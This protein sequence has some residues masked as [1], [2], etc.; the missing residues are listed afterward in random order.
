VVALHYSNF[1]SQ[2]IAGTWKVASTCKRFVP[3]PEFKQG[4]GPICF[5]I[6]QMGSDVYQFLIKEES[7][8]LHTNHD[9]MNASK[10]D[11]TRF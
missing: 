3:I 1:P 11:P 7:C 8:Y 9:S 10:I 4:C 6:F 5:V 2:S